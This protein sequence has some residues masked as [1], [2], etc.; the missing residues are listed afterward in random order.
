MLDKTRM[1]NQKL[2]EKLTEAVAKNDEYLDQIV[3]LKKDHKQLRRDTTSY[4][5]QYRN[6][7]KLNHEL[8][9]LYE[10]LSN[11]NKNLLTSSSAVMQKMELELESKKRELEEKGTYLK[12]LEMSV[13]EKE[14]KVEALEAGLKE[15][16]ARVDELEGIIS[17]KDAAVQKLK[18]SI[19]DAL[20]GFKESDL[21]VE[22][23]NGKVYVS[24]SE[25]LL[26]K[27]GSTVVDPK[28]VEALTKLADVLA[29]NKDI[30]ILIE[31]HTD[32][33][34]ITGAIK[35]N[36]DLSVLRA[37]SIVRILSEKNKVDPM[38]IMASGRGEFQPVSDNSDA[39]G[40]QKNRRTEIILTPNLDE[41]FKLL[42]SN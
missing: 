16:E 5:R 32:N 11:T 37:T 12:A 28:G 41:L 35:D 2:Q 29:E 39:A 33:V 9:E 7:T 22:T 27:S 31:G 36:W 15:R 20:L 14:K 24:L 21:T 17:E 38:R 30:S 40:R 34:P 8:N 19:T 42:E 25:K 10:K 1:E 3:R 23:K 13:L 26:F 6:I 18:K 4:G